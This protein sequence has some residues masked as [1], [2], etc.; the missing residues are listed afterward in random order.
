M[1]YRNDQRSLCKS[2]QANIATKS[3]LVGL[4]TNR[5]RKSRQFDTGAIFQ[6][7]SKTQAMLCY[8]IPHI[9]LVS[10]RCSKIILYWLFTHSLKAMS[11]LGLLNE[12][13]SFPCLDWAL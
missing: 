11:L 8:P 4:C 6:A 13:H 3:W 9:P 12:D 2:R 1:F 5:C 7:P 10:D